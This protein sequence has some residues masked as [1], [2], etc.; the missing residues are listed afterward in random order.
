[1]SLEH[2]TARALKTLVL[3]PPNFKSS[4][5]VEQALH[6]RRS[7]REY[8]SDPLTLQQFSQLLWSCQGI[9]SQEGF[10]TVPSAGAIFP[11]E[12][13]AVVSHVDGLAPGIYHYL[14]GLE[15]HVVEQIVLGDFGEKLFDLSTKQDF[16]KTVGVNLVL[17]TV[18][19]RMEKQYGGMALRYVL[20]E[21]GHAVQN[22]HLQ[23]EAL[24][25]GSVAV[26]YLNEDA[27]KEMLRMESDPLYMVSI[28]KKRG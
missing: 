26:G 1:M 9:T 25:L 6:V 19:A 14:P 10:R 24:G 20:M 11:L 3:P 8:T 13:Y 28:G 23:A 7:I 17:G 12:I 2:P 27:V 15:A 18:T 21:M 22:V 5:S 4:F 16:I